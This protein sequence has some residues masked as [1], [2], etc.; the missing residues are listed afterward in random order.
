M[1]EEPLCW[2]A[3]AA[4]WP[5]TPFSLSQSPDS[6]PD[7]RMD[8]F[9]VLLA[10]APLF[11]ASREHHC[12]KGISRLCGWPKSKA[13][14]WFSM[15]GEQLASLRAMLGNQD[16][17]MQ[18]QGLQITSRIRMLTSSERRLH[19]C[20]ALGFWIKLLCTQRST[21]QMIRDGEPNKLLTCLT[22]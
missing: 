18:T 17:S 2:T 20:Y 1:I 4:P 7:S 12:P 8:H 16:R 19:A 22:E 9:L 3:D 14:C 6:C 5:A 21:C 13:L 11:K 10:L 15:H